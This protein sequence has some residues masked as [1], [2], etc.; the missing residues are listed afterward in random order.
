MAIT[1]FPLSPSSALAE[2]I[3]LKM[4]TEYPASSMPGEG[5]QYFAELVA[6]ESGGQLT[7]KPSFSA[8]LG[9]KS[10][11]MINAVRDGRINAGDAFVGALGKIDPLFLVSS[12]PFLATTN[13]DAHKL[14]EAA[15]PF[16]AKRLA[17]EGQHLLYATPW[18]PSGIW[19]KKPI[20]KPADLSGL[21]MR[22]YDATGLKVF[23][24]AGAKAEMLS[25]TDTKPRL[26]DGS[27]VAV[28]SSG[29]G[30]AKRKL[31][32]FLPCFTEI[33]YAIPLSLAFLNESAY[34]ALPDN[35]RK[36]VD[37][38][39]K[40]TQAHQWGMLEGRLAK[41]YAEMKSN[42]VIITKVGEL[43]TELHALLSNSAAKAIDAW[44]KEVG[45][46]GKALLGK[47]GR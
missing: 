28:L 21:A 41:N 47:I 34:M 38:A 16:Y 1:L 36:A 8:E 33:N 32:N 22:T 3:E 27:I 17:A 5:L 35:L 4:A 37:R 39:A 40:A 30:G 31:W 26:A 19:A 25:F 10:A 20:K 46:Q 15:R 13:E 7:I 2:T 23:L 43:T 42:R 9:I 24:S 29:D 11:D 14:G 18:P 45:S 6:L 12:L 44:K